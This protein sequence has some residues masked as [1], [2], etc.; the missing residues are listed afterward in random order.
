[1][2]AEISR[3]LAKGIRTSEAVAFCPMA[4]GELIQSVRHGIL[5]PRFKNP[6]GINI[7]LNPFKLPDLLPG[8]SCSAIKNYYDAVMVQRTAAFST[9]GFKMKPSEATYTREDIMA[10]LLI[11]LETSVNDFDDVINRMKIEA[12]CAALDFEWA[13]VIL[14]P[15]K[16]MDFIMEHELFE[17]FPEDPIPEFI[18]LLSLNR[19]Y[20]PELAKLRWETASRRKGIILALNAGIFSYEPGNISPWSGAIPVIFPSDGVPISAIEGIELQDYNSE[21]RM[22]LI[23]EIH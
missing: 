22:I 3:W 10:R 20:T 12:R 13:S 4:A 11:S 9:V 1:M 8:I 23:P 21:E 15:E 18:R 16:R 6:D 5:V 7:A 17:S 14:D 2:T 19:G